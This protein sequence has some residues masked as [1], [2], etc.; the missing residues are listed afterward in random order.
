MILGIRCS[1][2]DYSFAVVHGTKDTPKLVASD[3]IPL[4][5]GFSKPHS[6]K[7]LY[8]EAEALLD[9]HDISKIVVKRFE[10]RTRGT[11]FENRV[12]NETAFM[13]AG[14]NRGM[15]AIFKKVKSTIAKDLGQK[16]RAKYLANLSTESIPEFGHLQD[17]VQEAVMA[18]RSELP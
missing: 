15:K 12:E 14:A 1:N 8:Q 18:A 2:K 6:L 10:G 5:K 9:K 7:W 16:G 3:T 4:P 17:K 11:I 13:L